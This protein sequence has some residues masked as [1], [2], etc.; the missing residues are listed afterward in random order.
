VVPSKILDNEKNGEIDKIVRETLCKVIYQ[1]LKEN[2][3]LTVNEPIVKKP[4]VFADSTKTTI[5]NNIYE[6]LIKLFQNILDDLFPS[7][8]ET[9]YILSM[10]FERLILFR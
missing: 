10:T 6:Q 8:E 9:R 5:D 7:N 2:L 1:A 4:V 3:I